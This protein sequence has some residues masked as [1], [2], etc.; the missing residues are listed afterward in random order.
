MSWLSLTGTP[1]L[2]LALLALAAI[3]V[4]TM[5]CWGRLGRLGIGQ[6]PARAALLVTGQLA[7][8][9]VTALVLND[10]FVFYQSWSEL[11]G[12]HPSNSQPAAAAGRLDRRWQF[13]IAADY[14][15]GKG[16]MVPLTVPGTRGNVHGE[17]ATVYLPPQYGDPAY[18]SRRFSVVELLD[19]FPGGP[20]TWVRRLHVATVLDSLINSGRATPFVAVLPVQNVSSPRDAE[21]VN[22]AGG[23]AVDTY[24]SYDVRSAVEQAFRVSDSGA[25]WGALGYST[26]GYCATDLAMRHPGLFAAAVSIA[27]YNAPAHDATTGN[28]FGRS[29]TATRLFSPSWLVRHQDAAPLRLLLISTKADTGS[30]HA[31]VQLAA[32][33]RPP[34]Q[35]STLTLPSGGHNFATFGAE[36][37]TAFGWLSQWLAMPLAPLPS[38]DGL[39]PS[40]GVPPGSGLTVSAKTGRPA[41]CPAITAAQA[42]HLPSVSVPARGCRPAHRTVRASG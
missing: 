26:G 39:L 23:P 31:A 33:A 38:V 22:V 18:R 7:A 14:R 35:V 41:R 8:V 27:G 24:L 5:L 28:L 2:C 17:V 30:Y 21:C 32:A 4:A 34:L 42:A 29:H 20:S 6:W 16:T 9:L 19:G 3:S 40:T 12:R 15:A 11:A 1:T 36:L 25:Q 37:P 13:Q 10:A